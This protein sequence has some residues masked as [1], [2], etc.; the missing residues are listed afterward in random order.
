VSEQQ[1]RRGR[2]IHG[3]WMDF[4][5]PNPRE[6][7][8]WNDTTASFTPEDWDAKVA[9]M[10]EA[11]MRRLV[12]MSV[13]LRGRSF[14][15]S[16]LIPERWPLKTEDPIAAVLEGAQRHGAE[17]YLGVGFFS[18]DTGAAQAQTRTEEELRRNI[19]QELADRYGQYSSFAG[20]Y[21]PVEAGVWGH[22][23]D[24][25]LPYA[26]SLGEWC[27]KAADKPVFIAPYGTRTII[28]DDKFVE[29][30]KALE[31][32]WLAWQDEVGVQKTRTDELPEI[33]ERLVKV[34]QASGKRLWMDIEVFVHE[35][36]VYKSPLIPAPWERLRQQLE[37]I[38][39]EVEEVLCYQYLGMMN[40]PGS[41]VLAGHPDSPKLY[42][43]YQAW[44]QEIEG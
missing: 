43:A 8:Y 13:A 22:F 17:V 9:E 42:E 11:G 24:V 41:R 18:E 5:H 31:V 7:D 25:Y 2:V 4:H 16:R 6:G 21:L 33:Y 40:K 1:T 32:D 30:L 26:N 44:R 36:V 12:I 34:H 39:S 38:P 27:R 37:A 35:G 19:P 15:P 28:P 10:V 14:Y 29:Q 3:T 20:W 23:P